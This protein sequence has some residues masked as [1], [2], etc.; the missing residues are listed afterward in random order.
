VHKQD[1]NTT[2]NCSD[3]SAISTA[4]PELRGFNPTKHGIT[5]TSCVMHVSHCNRSTDNHTHPATS[6]SPRKTVPAIPPPNQLASVHWYVRI[7]CVYMSLRGHRARRCALAMCADALPCLQDNLAELVSYLVHKVLQ[8]QPQA[9]RSHSQRD[10]VVR[11]PR[12]RLQERGL[13]N[14]IYKPIVSS[15]TSNGSEL[16]PHSFSG[17]LQQQSKELG[18]VLQSTQA[19]LLRET[20][21][22]SMV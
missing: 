19:A 7:T 16:S 20:T 13:A 11:Q 17:H 1:C 6:K 2:N 12:R 10:K 8:E 21:R 18:V 22:W 4:D 14:T 15:G 3:G 5:G 9:R